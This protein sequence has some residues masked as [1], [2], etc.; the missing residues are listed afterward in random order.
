MSTQAP[1]VRRLAIAAAVLIV[2]TLAVSPFV[3]WPVALLLG[4]NA[5]ALTLLGAV[6]PSIFRAD[7]PRTQQLAT[8]ED[9]TRDTARLLVQIACAASL[10]A[11]GSTLHLAKQEPG[12]QRT[13]FITVGVLTVLL[14][15]LVVNCVF[16]LRYADLF[17][18]CSDQAVD[19]GYTAA[20]DQPD[21]RDFAYLAF[22]IG[23][24]YQVSD[25]T[26]RD[27]RLRRTVLV[28]AFVSYFFGVVIVATGVNVVAGLLG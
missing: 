10:V 2:V 14:S 23:M 9:E 26:L 28:H 17:Y 20:G 15:W 24:T 8:R 13:L 19:F 21:Y 3:T 27:R 6:L 1:A 7:G 25:T 5:S 4:W 22:T 16:T 11:V 18:R 12:G